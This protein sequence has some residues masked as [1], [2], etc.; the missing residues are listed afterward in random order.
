MLKPP[1]LSLP[2]SYCHLLRVVTVKR[3]HETSGTGDLWDFSRNDML[4]AEAMLRLF[5]KHADFS[6]GLASPFETAALI[7]IS[8]S[9]VIPCRQKKL[10]RPHR[11]T[12]WSFLSSAWKEGR[13]HRSLYFRFRLLRTKKLWC[14]TIVDCWTASWSFG[15]GGGVE[16]FWSRIFIDS[17]AKIECVARISEAS[18]S[19]STWSSSDRAVDNFRLICIP[20]NSS[21]FPCEE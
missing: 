19:N 16:I 10:P 14:R 12:I 18:M 7:E 5:L 20:R 11:Q 15:W 4:H 3:L 8:W 17:T 13:L 6:R 21:S 2:P 9:L 1:S